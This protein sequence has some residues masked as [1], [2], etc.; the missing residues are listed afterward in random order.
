MVLSVVPLLAAVGTGHA[1]YCSVN[2]CAVQCPDG[3]AAA[4]VN[5]QCVTGC[6]DPDG[7]MEDSFWIQLDNA[8][9]SVR[10]SGKAVTQKLCFK[11]VTKTRGKSGNQCR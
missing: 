5:D 9:K 6:T 4:V 10:S 8:T 7:G 1:E 2:G 3:C 11:G